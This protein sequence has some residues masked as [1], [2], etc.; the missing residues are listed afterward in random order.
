MRPDAWR[1]ILELTEFLDAT[2]ETVRGKILELYPEMDVS[3]EGVEDW[4][5]F[6]HS[7]RRRFGC[8]VEFSEDHERR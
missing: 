4:Y 1:G 3:A 2:P 5:A 7:L 8:Q 6:T